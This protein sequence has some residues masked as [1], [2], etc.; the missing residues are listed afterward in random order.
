MARVVRRL[1]WLVAGC[2]GLALCIFLGG[3]A[4]S[5]K[6]AWSL[7]RIAAQERDLLTR[8]ERATVH[9][10]MQDQHPAVRA[11]AFQLLW[12]TGSCSEG[13]V[14]ALA[15]GVLDADE[16]VG[17]A[18]IQGLLHLSIAADRAVPQLLEVLARPQDPPHWIAGLALGAIG[19]GEADPVPALL[20]AARDRQAPAHAAAI[21]ALTYFGRTAEGAVPILIAALGTEE[22]DEVAAAAAAALANWDVDPAEVLEPL[23]ALCRRTEGQTRAG[24]VGA[25]A[26]F[27]PGDPEVLRVLAADLAAFDAD[28]SCNDLATAL[29]LGPAAGPLVPLL[30][31]RVG[32][33]TTDGKGSSWS[34]PF[35]WTQATIP[36]LWEGLLALAR[37]PA[38]PAHTAAVREL[39]KIAPAN[40][41]VLDFLTQATGD[42][43]VAVRRGA[44]GALRDLGDEAAPTTP[45]LLARIG[46]DADGVAV[47]L[48]V[49][50]LGA[51]GPAEPGRLPAIVTAICGIDPTTLDASPG[52]AGVTGAPRIPGG[53]S[54]DDLVRRSRLLALAALA[55][56]DPRALALARRELGCNRDPIQS[57]AIILLAEAGAAATDQ[58][59]ALALRTALWYPWSPG[60]A[61]D[62]IGR[63][64]RRDLTGMEALLG[65]LRGDRASARRRA[66]EALGTYGPAA[67]RAAADLIAA[68][69]HESP[70]V[71]AAAATA[72]GEIGPRARSAI[73]RLARLLDAGVP[74]VAA[75]A[76][77]ALGHIG[78]ADATCL[79][80]LA[81][82]IRDSPEEV[83]AA[84]G[85]SLVLLGADAADVGRELAQTARPWSPS[86]V[87]WGWIVRVAAGER[88]PAALPHLVAALERGRSWEERSAAATALADLATPADVVVPALK[89]A[90]RN[91]VHGYA[92]QYQSFYRR[93]IARCADEPMWVGENP[94]RLR[95]RFRISTP[96]DETLPWESAFAAL[97]RV[98]PTD[99]AALAAGFDLPSPGYAEEDRET[100]MRALACAGPA[101]RA[102]LPRLRL[103]ARKSI[104]PSNS[105]LRLW[106]RW[107][108]AQI[109]AAEPGLGP[110][111][112]GLATA[113]RPA[114]ARAAA[115]AILGEMALAP[116]GALATVLAASDDSDPWV[117]LAAVRA[118]AAA[119]A[120]DP[121]A[122]AVLN[123]A[124]DQDLAA[125]RHAA[126]T[127]RARLGVR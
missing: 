13:D 46:T 37:D 93:V 19:R 21:S 66:A 20:A 57:A 94:L 10:C 52:P 87:R 27:A 64:D 34:S 89:R 122:I 118:L 7:S 115:V 105:S 102:A 88:S 104:P 1:A 12:S 108:V 11:Q 30:L 121:Q 54:S 70:G 67:A 2:L 59:P 119:P 31:H 113:C 65:H 16:K 107:A 35:S 33:P 55:P 45:T 82:A 123:R 112:V 28:R 117:R 49:E 111:L 101:A 38:Q 51:I 97:R 53:N 90:V 116:A 86:V 110:E 72:L 60:L 81:S 92:W 84:A 32:D 80:A 4:M 126:R 74:Q 50:A 40:A 76:M 73:P 71:A 62:A 6:H 106:A 15:R 18:A 23:R 69:D 36:G 58:T 100:M 47:A 83:R 42:P 96:R 25:L 120:G 78:V 127:S 8:S 22:R 77:R 98:S 103:Y 39:G 26:H 68:L 61:V 95:S 29:E 14:P 109:D 3:L 75:A 44:L 91:L 85:A 43:D 114:A 24:V 5:F 41:E 63:I 125:V 9:A 79:G 99:F 17:S 48:A 124:V 56:G